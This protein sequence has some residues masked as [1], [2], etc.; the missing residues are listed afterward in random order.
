MFLKLFGAPLKHPSCAHQKMDHPKW[1]PKSSQGNRTKH[2][3][4]GLILQTLLFGIHLVAATSV[5]F[6]WKIL[7]KHC[8]HNVSDAL[9]GPNMGHHKEHQ[10]L[11]NERH[12]A[13][14]RSG[15]KKNERHAAWER[16]RRFDGPDG[17]KKKGHPKTAQTAYFKLF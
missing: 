9:A 14:E 11:Q 5:P 6:I 17:S 4:S 7:K 13:W 16:F 3:F 8:F 1:T 12:A 15:E 2:S 10:K